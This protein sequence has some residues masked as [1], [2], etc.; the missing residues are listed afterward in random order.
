[1]VPVIDPSGYVCE[2]VAS[3]RLEGVA[4]TIYYQDPESRESVLWDAAEYDQE[5]PLFTDAQGAYAWDVPTGRWQIQYEKAGYKI[6]YSDWLPVPP[7]QTEVN[8]ALTSTSAP[9]L[10]A[11]TVYEKEI[12]LEFSQ[13]MKPETVNAEGV[14]V[15]ADG[16]SVPGTVQ[17]V[18]LEASF[19]DS[20]VSYASIYRFIPETSLEGQI[21]I[22]V[23]TTVENYAGTVL[24]T[25][26][27][28]ISHVT[29]RPE[30]LFVAESTIVEY[31]REKVLTV[32]ILPAKAGANRTIHVRSSSPD[33]FS[34]KSGTVITDDDGKASVTINGNLPGSGELL[35]S[36]DGTELKGSVWVTVSPLV[37]D[38]CADVTASVIDGSTVAKGDVVR[39]MTAT[40][41]ATIYYT[42]DGSDPAASDSRQS[43]SEPI[44]ISTDARIRAYAVKDGYEDGEESN[45][46]YRLDSKALDGLTLTR[47]TDNRIEIS[48]TPDGGGTACA[49]AYTGDGI[50]IRITTL[51]GSETLNTEGDAAYYRFYL[52]DDYLRPIGKSLTIRFP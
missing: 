47:C 6:A 24:Q 21:K 9:H 46:S 10:N 28:T 4:T 11:V 48:G 49:S 33:I 8:A 1:M 19:E 39:L 36:L 22:V 12:R 32:Q 20:S 14:Y 29:P 42:L 23:K 40:E 34:V 26:Y 15:T 35:L 50:M 2:A 5:N 18:N 43:Y 27:S 31:H 41:D 16:V 38:T 30:T 7:P 45:F 44:T 25:E 3:N 17:P 51:H 52:I 13:Y 37:M